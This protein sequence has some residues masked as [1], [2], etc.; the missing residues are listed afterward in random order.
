MPLSDRYAP[1]Y[2][3]DGED[4]ILAVHIQPGASRDALAGTHGER[5]K[6]TLTAPPVN[7]RA[8]RKLLRYLAK[9]FGV[10]NG[11]VELLSG[12]TGRAKRIRIRQPVK[13]PAGIAARVN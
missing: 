6:I 11:R 13:L 10:P 12:Y 1:W 4:L 2:R 7:G 8:N 5:L 9:L 3:W